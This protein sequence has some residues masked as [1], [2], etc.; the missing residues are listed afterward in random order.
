VRISRGG[1]EFIRGGVRLSRSYNYWRN[2]SSEQSM[3]P[4][5]LAMIL[6]LRNLGKRQS[7]A[8]VSFTAKAKE[9]KV[10]VGERRHGP[11]MAV[12]LP[13]HWE[14][15]RLASA[16]R[17]QDRHLSPFTTSSLTLSTSP[18]LSLSLAQSLIDIMTDDERRPKRSRFDQ[19][20]P[21]PRRP[22]RIDRRSRSPLSRGPNSPARDEKKKPSVDPAAAAGML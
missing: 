22:S 19:T 6:D 12:L 10:C 21:E 9:G 2:G 15:G 3:V 16:K 20:E 14:P 5:R 13:R 17:G 11:T 8:E 18:L 1:C 7:I 4:G